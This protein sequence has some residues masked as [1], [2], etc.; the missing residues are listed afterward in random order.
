MLEPFSSF[1]IFAIFSHFPVMFSYLV[2]CQHN[3]NYYFAILTN[4]TMHLGAALVLGL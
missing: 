1:S 2:L 3:D 4:F